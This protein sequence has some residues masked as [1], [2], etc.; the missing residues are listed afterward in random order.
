M[1]FENQTKSDFCVLT[2]RPEQ[3][4]T[5]SIATAWD[6]K[7]STTQHPELKYTLQLINNIEQTIPHSPI[8]LRYILPISAASDL[9]DI[10]IC[11]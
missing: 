1:A 10:I 7:Q 2:I 4:M 8:L 6:F 3:C 5:P 11:K 9:P